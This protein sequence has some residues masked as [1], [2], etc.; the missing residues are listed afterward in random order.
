[1][2]TFDNSNNY[3]LVY[4]ISINNYDKYNITN[5][6]QLEELNYIIIKKNIYII[7]FNYKPKKIN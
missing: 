6:T 3:N 2:N 4:D 5:N 7:N 1:M